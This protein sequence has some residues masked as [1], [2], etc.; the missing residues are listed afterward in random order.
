M[1]QILKLSHLAERYGV[2]QMHV[3][4]CRVDAVLDSQRNPGIGALLQFFPQFFL[5][6]DFFDAT[7]DDSKLVVNGRK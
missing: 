7:G 1:S 6:H 5:R 3:N 4:A 2:P